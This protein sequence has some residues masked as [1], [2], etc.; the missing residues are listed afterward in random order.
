MTNFKQKTSRD[1][2]YVAYIRTLPCCITGA[3]PPSE[4]HH[5]T[6]CGMGKKGSDYET[7]PLSW[8]EH[9]KMENKRK[10]NIPNIETIINRL[11]AK[12]NEK[13]NHNGS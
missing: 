10:D 11:R 6:N 7:V 2:S 5:T 13:E 9:R 3:P 8:Q 4:A 12:Y 1:S